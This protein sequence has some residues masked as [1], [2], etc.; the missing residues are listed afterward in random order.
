MPMIR[1]PLSDTAYH[2]LL[3]AAAAEW[4]PFQ[5]HAAFLLQRG[6]GVSEEEVLRDLTA[7]SK[8]RVL[9]PEK[10]SAAQLVSEDPAAR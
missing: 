6:L 4:R 2:K 7:A 3:N 1:V 5:W 10:R 9:K 8:M